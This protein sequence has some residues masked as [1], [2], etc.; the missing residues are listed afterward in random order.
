[1]EKQKCMQPECSV[2]DIEIPDSECPVTPW[3]DWSPCSATCGRGV[4]IRTRLL[5]VEASK[6]ATCKKKLE[7]NH[8]RPCVLQNNCVFNFEAAQEL[9]LQEPEVGPCRGNY[10]RY[11]YDAH[12]ETCEEFEFGGNCLINCLKIKCKRRFQIL[13]KYLVK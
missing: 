13:S 4:Q 9:C 10:K 1:M 3:S 2:A 12:K 5:L 7:L 11:F 6:E 8:Q